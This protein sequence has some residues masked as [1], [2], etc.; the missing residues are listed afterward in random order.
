MSEQR[1]RV[2]ECP[3]DAYFVE[4][5]SSCVPYERGTP[6]LPRV[7]RGNRPVAFLSLKCRSLVF[8]LP[9]F[10]KV[11]A[12]KK[13]MGSS[14]G[15]IRLKFRAPNRGMYRDFYPQFWLQ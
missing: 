15:C 5:L 3:G 9:G 2:A 10:E 13:I 12:E 8:F 1:G 6:E 7:G 14:L 11:S 4:C